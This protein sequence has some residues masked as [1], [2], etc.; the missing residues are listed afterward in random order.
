MKSK[1]SLPS[2]PPRPPVR[3]IVAP[4][5]R[6]PRD[7]GASANALERA[8]RVNEF[9]DALLRY[10][11]KGRPDNFALGWAVGC[12][13]RGAI[14]V[15]TK[16]CE[17]YDQL[18]A[19]H[20]GTKNYARVKALDVWVSGS[21]LWMLGAPH[22]QTYFPLMLYRVMRTLG[23]PLASKYESATIARKRLLRGLKRATNVPCPMSKGLKRNRR[24]RH[25]LTAAVLSLYDPLPQRR[26][27]V[28]FR[29]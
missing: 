27:R 18:T 25:P 10:L 23:F 4:P 17:L 7:C 29:T 14:P 21:I 15:L 6:R 26:D 24:S 9:G 20:P 12:L 11:E 28:A 8:N 1:I 22:F 5:D 2:N 13:E 3:L 19:L 16:Q